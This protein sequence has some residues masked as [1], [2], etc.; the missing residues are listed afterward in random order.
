MPS[1]ARLLD[2]GEVRA[3]QAYIV[4]RNRAAANP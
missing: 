2:P 3:I 1:F 4:S